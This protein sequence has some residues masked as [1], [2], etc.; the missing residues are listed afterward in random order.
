M[1][2]E[3]LKPQPQQVPWSSRHVPKVAQEHR[4]LQGPLDGVVEVQRGPGGEAGSEADVTDARD[5]HRVAATAVDLARA[6]AHVT[7][8]FDPGPPASGREVA[9]LTQPGVSTWNSPTFANTWATHLLPR[10]EPQLPS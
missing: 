7:A 5:P 2:R 3:W 10:K 6:Q 1:W 9:S 8:D 4:T